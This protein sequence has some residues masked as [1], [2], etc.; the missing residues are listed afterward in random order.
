MWPSVIHISGWD[1]KFIYIEWQLCGSLHKQ[2]LSK[3]T[4]YSYLRK[5]SWARGQCIVRS[6]GISHIVP[7]LITKSC[8]ISQ[9]Q[10]S[11]RKSETLG[12]GS[13]YPAEGLSL[14]LKTGLQILGRC[15]WD[16]IFGRGF[17]QIW[18]LN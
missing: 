11:S 5:S 8:L 10:I 18:S 15:S 2:L 16:Q 7:W 4:S 17:H 12:R 9:F 14:D 13:W 6:G 3:S 1:K